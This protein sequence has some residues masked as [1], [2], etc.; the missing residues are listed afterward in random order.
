LPWTGQIPWTGKEACCQAASCRHSRCCLPSTPSTAPFLACGATSP[1]D[2]KHTAELVRTSAC[3]AWLGTA[4]TQHH[5][6]PHP[7]QRRPEC[8]ARRMVLASALLPITLTTT[9]GATRTQANQECCQQA[10]KGQQNTP[11]FPPAPRPPPQG[12]THMEPICSSVS[13]QQPVTPPVFDTAP[14]STSAAAATT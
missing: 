10:R 6:A 7:P 12:T 13:W 3:P 9:Q 5:S 1:T 4:D 11:A 8:R 2:K 14:A